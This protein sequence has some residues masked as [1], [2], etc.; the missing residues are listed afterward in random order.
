MSLKCTV[1]CCVRCPGVEARN[2]FLPARLLTLR[3]DCL[4]SQTTMDPSPSTLNSGD[5]TKEVDSGAETEEVDSGAE[6]EEVDSGAEPEEVKTEKVETYNV[7]PLLTLV[8]LPAELTRIIAFRCFLIGT[9]LHMVSYLRTNANNS[10]DSNACGHGCRRA[11]NTCT[12]T[13]T[14]AGKPG[15]TSR[16]T[17]TTYRGPTR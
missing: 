6:P 14:G 13:S 15:A 1:C 11:D 10:T 8:G 4:P 5:K 9:S 2:A 17:L 16:N 7:P 12:Y 3:L